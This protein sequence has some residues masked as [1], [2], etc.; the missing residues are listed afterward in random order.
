MDECD[1]VA[2]ILQ[3]G[4]E[5]APT[6]TTNAIKSAELSSSE[7]VL[8]IEIQLIVENI[9][10]RILFLKVA[11]GTCNWYLYNGLHMCFE[12]KNLLHG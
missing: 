8:V 1:R 5:N 6:L 12:C 4:Q 11:S 10:L 9:M 7:M 3:C 2:Q